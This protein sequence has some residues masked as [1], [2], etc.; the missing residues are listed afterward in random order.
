MRIS[1]AEN[2]HSQSSNEVFLSYSIF[3]ITNLLSCFR[4]I[5]ICARTLDRNYEHP[6]RLFD[7]ELGP[8]AENEDFLRRDDAEPHIRSQNIIR[9]S[10]RL[11]WHMKFTLETNPSLEKLRRPVVEAEEK[12]F[13]PA[14]T[15]TSGSSSGSSLSVSPFLK[16]TVP[17]C[18]WRWI[19]NPF[20]NRKHQ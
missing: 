7:I 14:S 10:K 17:C 3:H 6:P 4:L 8:Y 15:V 16:T 2:F 12:T 18:P 20:E 13:D 19:P 11:R 1:V 9:Y 5:P